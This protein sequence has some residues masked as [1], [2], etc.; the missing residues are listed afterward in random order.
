MQGCIS[1]LTDR[2]KFLQWMTPYFSNSA[3][4]FVVLYLFNYLWFGL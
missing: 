3:R 4:A 1:N 2:F